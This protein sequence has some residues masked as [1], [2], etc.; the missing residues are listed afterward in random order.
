MSDLFPEM[1]GEDPKKAKDGVSKKK[2][3]QDNLPPNLGKAVRLP[4]PDFNDPNRKLTCLEVD[5]PIAPINALARLEATSGAAKKPI[6]QMSKW[7]ARRQSSVF[8]SMLIAAATEAPDNPEDAAKLVWEN[9]YANHQKGGA[10]KKLRVLDPFMGGG[11]TLVEGSRLGLHVTGVDLNP[12]AWFVVKN[13]VACSDPYQVKAFFAAI[14]REV[15]PLIQPFYTTTCPR[16]H[17]GHWIDGDTGKIANVDPIDLPPDERKSYRWE[18]PEVIYTFW[19]KHGPCQAHG[20]NHRT[21]IFRTPIIAEK[22][23][24]TNFIPLTCPSCHGEFHAELGETRMAPGSER[25][26]LDNE[27]PFTEMSQLFAK[28]LKDYSKGNGTEK[29]QR[30]AHLLD[31]VDADPGLCCPGCGTFSG[32]KLKTVLEMHRHASKVSDIAKKELGIESKKVYMYLLMRPEWLK[33]SPGVNAEGEELGGYAGADPERTAAWYQE[34]LKGL[35]L[36]EVRGRVKLDEDGVPEDEVDDE[37]VASEADVEEIEGVGESAESQDAKGWGPPKQLTLAD[38]TILEPHKGTVPKRSNFRCE[39]CGRPQDFLES[40]RETKHTAPVFPY[41]LQCH[42]PQCQEEG[43]Q[44]NG[45]F[46]KQPDERDAFQSTQADREWDARKDA[47]LEG[48]WPKTPLFPSFMTHRLNGG[49]PNWGYTHWWKMFNSRQLLVHT[50]LMRGIE[51]IDPESWPLDVR[52]QA[53]GAFQQ[54]LRSMCMLSFYHIRNDQIAPALSNPNYH[55]KNQVIETCV[56]KDVGS[57]AWTAYVKNTCKGVEWVHKP[58]E[59]ALGQRSVETGDPVLCGSTEL[60][61]ASSSFLPTVE[62]FD[63][64]ITD[65][66]FG[67]LLYYA[68]L[69]EFFY[70]WLRLPL[71][72]FYEGQPE[73]DYFKPERTPHAQEAIENP[74]EHPDDREPHEAEKIIIAEHLHLIRKLSEDDILQIGD[75]NPLYRREPAPD[76]YRQTLQACW[77]EAGRLLKPGGIL[78]FTFHHKDDAP[79]VDVLESLFDADYVLSMTYPIRSDETK[80]SKGQFGSRKIEYD[81]IHV[82]R[83]R[84]GEVEPVSWA[85]MRR[86]VRQEVSRLKDLLEHA[87]GKEITESDMLIILRGK[88]LEFFSRHYGQVYTGDGQVLDVRNALLGINQILDDLRESASSGPRP[89]EAAEPATRLMLRI[90]LTNKKVTRDDI[91]KTLRGTGIAPDDFAQWGWVRIVGKDV[92]PIPIAERFDAFTQR[93]RTRKVLKSDLDVAHF[94]I[95]AA[96]S[97]GKV[98]IMQE[99][100][101]GNLPLRRSVDEVIGWYQETSKDAEVRTGAATAKTLLTQFRQRRQDLPK[102]LQLSIFEQLEEAEIAS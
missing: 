65:P 31:T 59:P 17:K 80:G 98:D 74:F 55:P 1:K 47:D 37:T 24:T 44:Y 99:L 39:K 87:H 76:F 84:L 96:T 70:Q 79:W 101:T 30:V 22:T 88:S 51:Q 90:F 102:D 60:I 25:V 78:A 77:A 16:G 50:Q 66:P 89:P 58:D 4:V 12:V 18:G 33:G 48:F 40:V 23:L 53:L 43:Y 86:W 8:R 57:G 82:C 68:D 6:Y 54:Y 97:G 14:E 45:R 21:P 92:Y 26:V 42:C 56:F 13:E 38:G 49:I 91:G 63:C 3:A 15:K 62:T 19:A 28:E 36:V 27:D 61:C 11:T 2:A 73:A 72:R 71:Q 83:K 32:G 85:K 69:A 93:G 46:F 81:I 20:C 35:A 52:E 9:Y 64:A 95:G 67:N 94:L 41:S 10:F 34:R 100:R 29:R 5:F 75:G 7:W